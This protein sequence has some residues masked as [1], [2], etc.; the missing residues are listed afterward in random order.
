MTSKHAVGPILEANDVAD[1]VIEA[2]RQLDPSVQV[3]DRGAYLRVVC[4]RICVLERAR[5]EALL[6]RP[7]ELPGALEQVMPSFQGR[8]ELDDD[9]VVWRSG[10]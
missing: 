10:T 9:R 1:A 3:I 8:I 2:I 6:Q 7:F 4:D 5:V